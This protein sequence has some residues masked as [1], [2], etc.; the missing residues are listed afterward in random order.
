[1]TPFDRIASAVE[2]LAASP[3]LVSLEAAAKHAGLSP[4][5]FQRTFHRLVG[6]TPQRFQQVLR[7]EAAREALLR[8]RSVLDAAWDGGLSGPGRLHDALVRLEAMTPGELKAGP[9]L[10]WTEVPTPL[11]PLAIAATSRGLSGA[12]FDGLQGLA[13]RWPGA[14]L[15]RDDA[16][17]RS[18]ARTLARAL[19]GATP[20]A[21][22]TVVVPGTPLQLAVWRALLE[23]PEGA[24]VT[25][26]QLAERCG[27]PSASRAVANA[28]GANRVAWLIPCHRVIRSTGALGGYRWGLGRKAALLARELRDRE[29]GN[30][31]HGG[32]R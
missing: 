21:P 1:M 10:R 25:Y 14:T 16:G 15:T 22:L 2:H 32:A 24:V 19:A 26:S 5:H 17:L 31:A 12:S 30:P 13:E 3:G 23:I 6:V 9:A 27:H 11:G 18:I 29:A 7:T 20:H 4:F 8:S 28:V